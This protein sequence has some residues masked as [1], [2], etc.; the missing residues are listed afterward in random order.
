[1]ARDLESGVFKMVRNL[2]KVGC[3]VVAGSNV[4]VVRQGGVELMR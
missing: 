4:G 1:M 3:F 2:K